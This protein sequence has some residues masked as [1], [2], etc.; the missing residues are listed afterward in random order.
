MVQTLPHLAERARPHQFLNLVPPKNA[1]A[2][3]TDQLSSLVVLLLTCARR[4]VYVVNG[5][6]KILKFLP[7]QVAQGPMVLAQ[8][9]VS[10]H[11]KP[12][13]IRALLRL[14]LVTS[15]LKFEMWAA[16][17]LGR[18]VLLQSRQFLRSQLC[19]F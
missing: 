19:H 15:L 5:L 3:F 18:H 6:L 14:A 7:L 12:L 8:T 13:L 2:R 4:R 10:R 17:R 1:L 9:L 16:Q 11:G